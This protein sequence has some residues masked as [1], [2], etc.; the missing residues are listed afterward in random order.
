[1]DRWARGQGNLPR[2]DCAQANIDRQ[3]TRPEPDYRWQ[4][5]H[6]DENV[7]QNELAHWGYERQSSTCLLPRRSLS[8]AKLFKNGGNYR[9]NL[10]P[11]WTTCLHLWGD[12][13]DVLFDHRDQALHK[14]GEVWA[15]LWVLPLQMVAELLSTTFQNMA[16]P[17]A[18]DIGRLR[19]GM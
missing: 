3:H 7:Q 18:D 16:H 1:M 13:W 5:G 15:S 8:R 10:R 11:W 19:P 17:R 4:M 6:V 12:L 2:C 14:S 9:V